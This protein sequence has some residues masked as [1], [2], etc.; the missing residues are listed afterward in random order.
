M[1]GLAL[2]LGCV[3]DNPGFVGNR[4]RPSCPDKGWFALV[5]LRVFRPRP[6]EEQLQKENADRDNNTIRD[7]AGVFESQVCMCVIVAHALWAMP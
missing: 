2:F 3:I 5:C 1:F 4:S 6:A 7:E